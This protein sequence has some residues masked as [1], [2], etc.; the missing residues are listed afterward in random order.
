MLLF[1]QL[2]VCILFLP[3]EV[4][5]ETWFWW[6]FYKLLVQDTSETCQKYIVKPRNETRYLTKRYYNKAIVQQQARFRL[7][8]I[9]D[10]NEILAYIFM[11]IS[12]KRWLAG[13]T[14]SCFKSCAPLGCGLPAHLSAKVSRLSIWWE[15][16]S[17]V[18]FPPAERT[19]IS[20]CL[21]VQ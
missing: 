19:T 1:N 5:Q 18:T 14:P 11:C 8:W 6:R 10:A 12:L 9:N 21:L 4:H 3:A 17:T 2:N 16:Y 15:I 7:L 13:I 20:R